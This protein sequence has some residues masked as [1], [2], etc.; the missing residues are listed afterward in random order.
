MTKV[1]VC[2]EVHTEHV[3]ARCV[4]YIDYCCYAFERLMLLEQIV[5]NLQ[6]LRFPHLCLDDLGHLGCDAL[7]VVVRFVGSRPVDEVNM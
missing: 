5:L 7:S 6:V 3:I 4:Q 2:S 1:V